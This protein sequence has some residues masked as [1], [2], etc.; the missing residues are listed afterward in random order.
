MKQSRYMVGER[1]GV[2]CLLLFSVKCGSPSFGP[3]SF[4]LPTS[5]LHSSHVLKWKWLTVTKN[6]AYYGTELI[7]TVT[8]VWHPNK[9]PILKNILSII[10]KFLYQARVFFRLGWKGLPKTNTLAYYEYWLFHLSPSLSS[11]ATKIS[12]I[13]KRPKC[14]WKILNRQK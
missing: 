12:K 2:S 8:S 14:W 10:Y 5:C 11:Y 7:T 4:C 1:L 9:G 3:L 6:L 13:W